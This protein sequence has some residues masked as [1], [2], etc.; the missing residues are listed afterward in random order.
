MEAPV[1]DERSIY[2]DRR[3]QVSGPSFR[4]SRQ[5]DYREAGGGRRRSNGRLQPPLVGALLNFSPLDPVKAL[6][7]SAVVNGVAAVP[8]M[9]MIMHMASRRDVMGE[10]AVKR[11]LKTL[12][13]VATAV[14]TAA[15][16][17]MFAYLEQLTER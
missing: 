15:A 13:W 2:W 10:F 6:F 11:W 7:W 14:M 3:R 12:G 5:Q 9:V 4:C 16:V 1:G 8:I 17:G